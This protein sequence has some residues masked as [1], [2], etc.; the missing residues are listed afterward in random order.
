MRGEL[1]QVDAEKKSDGHAPYMFYTNHPRRNAY[2]R[3]R[4]TFRINRRR[5]R[6]EQKELTEVAYTR[7]ESHI[8]PFVRTQT[9]THKRPKEAQSPTQRFK[10]IPSSSARGIAEVISVSL[11]HVFYK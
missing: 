8:P 11:F 6:A 1:G 7:P 4:S 9:Q 3:P 5:T 2:N 10:R